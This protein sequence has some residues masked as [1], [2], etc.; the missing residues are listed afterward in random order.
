MQSISV[1][2][3]AH[4]LH[5]LSNYPR[6]IRAGFLRKNPHTSVW[7]GASS[8]RLHFSHYARDISVLLYDIW[9]W[10]IRAVRPSVKRAALSLRRAIHHG[11]CG[12]PSQVRTLFIAGSL[13]ARTAGYFLLV[14]LKNSPV[15]VAASMILRSYITYNVCLRICQKRWHLQKRSN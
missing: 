8:P 9:G 2:L 11:N 7:N 5:P 14:I 13:R 6:R 3:M 1:P 10:A 4:P 15:A 12:H